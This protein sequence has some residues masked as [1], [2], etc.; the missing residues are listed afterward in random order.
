[1]EKKV[2]KSISVSFSIFKSIYSYAKTEVLFN[3]STFHSQEIVH[4]T[5]FQNEAPFNNSC[6]YF[7]IVRFTKKTNRRIPG[8]FTYFETI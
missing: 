2:R 3:N 1:M 4:E 8:K 7:Q 5:R 6:C